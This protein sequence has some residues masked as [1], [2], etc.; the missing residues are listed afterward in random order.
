MITTAYSGGNAPT[1]EPQTRDKR[2]GIVRESGGFRG[3]HSSSGGGD[4]V[5]RRVRAGRGG[6]ISTGPCGTALLAE[7]LGR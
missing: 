7:V 2:D 3:G 6:G 4:R 5:V 1:Q